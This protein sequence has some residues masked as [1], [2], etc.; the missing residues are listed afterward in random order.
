MGWRSQAQRRQVPRPTA[1]L[2]RGDRRSGITE[3][4]YIDDL[5]DAY[6]AQGSGGG[7]DGD[8]SDDDDKDDLD[9]F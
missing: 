1:R 5:L 2:R 3:G 8:G 6:E 7:D 9:D 4:E